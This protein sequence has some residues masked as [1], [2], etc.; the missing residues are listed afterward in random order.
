MLTEE[1]I[2]R[3]VALRRRLHRQPELSGRERHTAERIARFVAPLRPD[4][5]VRGLGGHG[6]AVVFTG[7]RP[8]PTV[9]L[10]CELDALPIREEGAARHRSAVDGCAHACG[11]DGHMAIL[12]AVGEG[13]ARTRPQR[14]RAVL[15]YQP[16]EETGRG[17]TAV[18]ADPR[19]AELRPDL[20]FALH[21][22]PGYPLGRIVL[23][24]GTACCASTGMVIALH[25][26]PAH[27]AQPETG[28]SPTPV[29]ARLIDL[30]NRLPRRLGLDDG[31]SFATVVGARLGDAE[32]FG[33]APGEA[34]VLATLRSDR[35]E[36]LQRMV[37]FVATA[38]RRLARRHGLGH[39]I[40]LR[41][42]FAAT[43]NA[44]RAVDLVRRAAGGCSISVP[45]RPFRWSEDF[46]RFTAIAPGALVG[47]GAGERTA[48]LHDPVYDFPD[49]LV[50]IGAQLLT[51]ILRLSFES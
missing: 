2:Q 48:A 39:G 10:R 7:P 11:H 4:L 25:G 23:R 21:N 15:L 38:V 43:V 14:G 8:G 45:R 22:L 18:L 51:R 1:V 28:A 34:R 42:E 31:R 32:A 47:L 12:A 49:E 26:V 3:A 44:S 36:T 17:A 37:S 20:A 13:L 35:D 24:S 27:A 33:T 5:V 6:L 50:P 29:V 40:E 19:F 41:D 16:A 46:G 9:L 30:L